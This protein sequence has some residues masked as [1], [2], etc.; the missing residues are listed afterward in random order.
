M[1]RPIEA[2]LLLYVIVVAE[3]GSITR[4]AKKK[5]FI[6][7]GSLARDIRNLEKRIGY[8]LFV[9]HWGGV[10]LTP[11]GMAFVEEARKSLEHSQRAADRGAAASRGETGVLNIGFTPFLD[12]ARLIEIRE[13]FAKAMP[14]MAINFRGAYCSVQ[15]ELVLR[16]ILDAGLVIVPTHT[17][18]LSARWVGRTQLV[19][20]VPERSRLAAL[21]SLSIRELCGEAAVWL[22]RDVNPALYDRLLDICHKGGCV[23][24]VVRSALTYHEMLDAISNGLGVGFVRKSTAERM[25]VQGVVFRELEDAQL[26]VDVGIVYRT[27]KVSRGLQALLGVLADLSG[28]D[29]ESPPQVSPG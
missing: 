2:R 16:E 29:E 14:E 19:V 11:G 9:R 8:P 7:P 12:T 27:D 17:D 4:A 26:S 10:A 13:R 1:E 6:V 18:E 20:A 3:E 21:G 25:Q 23:P 24:N 28:S 15:V 22:A 5:L